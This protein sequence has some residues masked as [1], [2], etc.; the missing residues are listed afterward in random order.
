MNLVEGQS[1][2]VFIADNERV[3]LV[4][5]DAH[6]YELDPR[7]SFAEVRWRL[8][9]IT[10]QYDVT[11][12]EA[13][14]FLIKHGRDIEEALTQRGNEMLGQFAAAAKMREFD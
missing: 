2:T 11:E 8:E 9:D 7:E 4:D 10:D 12:D 3:V 6:K 14:K 5:D 1:L 13:R